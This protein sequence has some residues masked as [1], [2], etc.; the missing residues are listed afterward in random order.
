MSCPPNNGGHFTCLNCRKKLR[1]PVFNNV[2]RLGEASARL[3]NELV[4]LLMQIL[5][6]RVYGTDKGNARRAVVEESGDNLTAAQSDEN[7]SGNVGGVSTERVFKELCVVAAY[8]KNEKV[9]RIANDSVLEFV[10]V[11][12]RKKLVR[13]REKK[14]VL[15]CLSEG[16]GEGLRFVGQKALKFIDHEVK[17]DTVS[18]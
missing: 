10:V 3:G 16:R 1:D 9:S 13:E 2:A 5:D 12:L 8:P 18:D 4:A 11:N 14:F 15:A 7:I 6:F 17:G